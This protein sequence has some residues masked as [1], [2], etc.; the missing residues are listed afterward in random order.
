MSEP[1]QLMVFLGAGLP[2][3]A[4]VMETDAILRSNGAQLDADSML[5]LED[6]DTGQ[7]VT[8]GEEALRTLA[9]SPALGSISYSTP[10]CMITVTFK[11]TSERYVL[12]HAPNAVDLP[13][14]LAWYLRQYWSAR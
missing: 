12:F 14:A 6:A 5:F 8:N 11:G 7:A 13:G 1:Y 2:A 4:V 9:R 10:E 3:S